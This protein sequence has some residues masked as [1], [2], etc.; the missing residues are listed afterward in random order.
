[1]LMTS[2]NR[3]HSP[4]SCPTEYCT[5]ENYTSL[6]LCSFTEDISPTIFR[7]QNV[8]DYPVFLVPELDEVPAS[9]EKSIPTNMWMTTLVKS[10]SQTGEVV[11]PPVAEVYIL[12]SSLCHETTSMEEWLKVS[13]D[14]RSWKALKGTFEF[15]LK[16]QNSIY[17]YSME[18]TISNTQTK[19]RWT[20][21]DGRYYT[22]NDPAQTYSISRTSSML[23]SEKLQHVFNGSL[24]RTSSGLRY[25]GQWTP[26][27]ASDLMEGG[28]PVKQCRENDYATFDAFTRRL[29]L[30][31]VS[32]S[33]S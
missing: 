30:V 11:L 22:S 31:S 16:T 32:I 1:M 23:L 12:Y 14:A 24:S 29:D 26:N 33:Q 19:L 27:V 13:G 7:D 8:P 20:S 2:A 25:S 15:C 6:A 28:L 4:G 18:T 3:S 5:W 9:V 10:S 21:E 17:N